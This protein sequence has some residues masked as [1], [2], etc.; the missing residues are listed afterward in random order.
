MTKRVLITGANRGIGLALVQVF[1]THSWNVLACC[2]APGQAEALQALA[3]ENP[4][5]EVIQLDVTDEAAVVKLG[6]DLSNQMVD[7]LINNAGVSLGDNASSHLTKKDI[8]TK[9]FEVN[10]IAPT[11]LTQALYPSIQRSQN[12]LVVMISSRMASIQDNRLGGAYAYRASKTALNMVTK[13]LSIDYAPLGIKCL[14]VDPGWV[15]T[16]MG[17]AT[18]S[19]TPQE[20]AEAIFQLTQRAATLESGGFYRYDGSFTPV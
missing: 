1:A 11:L 3:Q 12:K 2:R 15:Q 17:G 6:E 9:T 19:I 4:H 5:I 8:F 10:T 14:A 18:A 20:S 13:S 7:I 16:D